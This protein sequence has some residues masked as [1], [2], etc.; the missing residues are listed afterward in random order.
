MEAVIEGEGAAATAF[1]RTGRFDGTDDDG[2]LLARD[3]DRF[4]K[5][6]ESPING[7]LP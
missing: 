7:A 6:G 2:R 4:D 1:V 5:V 3:D